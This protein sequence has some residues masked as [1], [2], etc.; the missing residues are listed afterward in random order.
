[1]KHINVLPTHKNNIVLAA[2]A[3]GIQVSLTMHAHTRKLYNEHIFGTPV[4][5]SINAYIQFLW[6]GHDGFDN[7]E[8]VLQT[9]SNH[10]I[11]VDLTVGINKVFD[12]LR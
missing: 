6:S 2:I 9:N 10:N 8:D 4:C 12:K 1:M 3:L 5:T 7:D 11:R